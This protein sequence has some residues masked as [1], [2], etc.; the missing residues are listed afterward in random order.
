M[1]CIYSLSPVIWVAP[2]IELLPHL[3]STQEYAEQ[4]HTPKQ[5]YANRKK[6]SLKEA[7]AD[8]QDTPKP[9]IQWLEKHSLDHLHK[10]K[11]WHLLHLRKYIS[12]LLKY[13]LVLYL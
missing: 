1:Q 7:W 11:V 9:L 10:S 5:S 12:R 4:N 6:R 3:G 2:P 13:N 8:L